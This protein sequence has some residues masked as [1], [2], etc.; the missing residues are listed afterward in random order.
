MLE[1]VEVTCV[2]ELVGYLTFLELDGFL[3]WNYCLWP[4]RP[5]DDLRWRAPM[6]KVGDTYFVLP[7]RDGWP[8]DICLV[9]KTGGPTAWQLFAVPI[10]FD[11]DETVVANAEL[12]GI[13]VAARRI[14]I[15]SRFTNESAVVGTGI[16]TFFS[17]PKRTGTSNLVGA[18]RKKLT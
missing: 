9:M 13:I 17:N 7:G 10:V 6:W 8:V 15:S 2:G 16:E 12:R 4:S 14:S 11:N 1:L 3:R 5:W 18:A